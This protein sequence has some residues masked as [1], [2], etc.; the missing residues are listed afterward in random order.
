MFGKMTW[1]SVRAEGPPRGAQAAAAAAAFG[2]RRSLF[3]S[4]VGVQV[5][6]S[7]KCSVAFT[8]RLDVAWFRIELYSFE[9][10]RR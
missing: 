4:V 9:L 3:P 2:N 6:V 7:N 1:A 8:A 10:C 5:G